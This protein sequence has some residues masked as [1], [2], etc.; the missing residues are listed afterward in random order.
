[1]QGKL[2][3]VQGIS[4]VGLVSPVDAEALARMPNLRLL[5]ADGVD[6]KQPLRGLDLPALAML[7]WR[8]KAGSELSFDW[9]TARTAVVIDVQG[10]PTL[11]RLPDDM[12]A[13]KPYC[14]HT[15]LLAVLRS[16]KTSCMPGSANVYFRLSCLVL[17]HFMPW[18]TSCL[19]YTHVTGKS[20]YSTCS[21]K[22]LAALCACRL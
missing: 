20:N 18:P 4:M 15:C 3:H 9:Y 10:H 11:A 13:C 17:A 8:E 2:E 7:S 12:Q 22:T 19:L 6:V 21:K 14:N 1:M 5:N 16:Y